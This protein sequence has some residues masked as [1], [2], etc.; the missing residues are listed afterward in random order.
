MNIR[1]DIKQ[2][3]TD[4][5]TLRKFG[6]VVGGVF[7]LLGLVLLHKHRPA[8]PYFLGVGGFLIVAGLVVPR[9]LRLIYLAWMSLAV[10]LGFIVSHV[11]LA[12]FFYLVITPVGWVA[13][14]F[15]NDFLGLK[16][17]PQ[18]KSYWLPCDPK[19]KSAADY[20]RQF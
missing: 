15:G 11:L 17:D 3:K 20:E 2:L 10:V 9:G 7:A 6:L 18:A 14:I 12:V 13:R 5:S 4:T 1:D 8:A 19:K 16:L